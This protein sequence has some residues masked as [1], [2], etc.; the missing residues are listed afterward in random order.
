MSHL[1][2]TAIAQIEQGRSLYAAFTKFMGDPVS[3]RELLIEAMKNYETS[4]K[5][6][7]LAE[8]FKIAMEAKQ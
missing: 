5:A 2:T 7:A 1:L 6:T 3:S 4:Y 8:V